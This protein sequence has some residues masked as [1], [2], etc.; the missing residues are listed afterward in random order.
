MIFWSFWSTI[1]WAQALATAALTVAI[2]LAPQAF[3]QLRYIW[4][5]WR[6]VDEPAYAAALPMLPPMFHCPCGMFLPSR[7]AAE[8]HVDAIHPGFAP[9]IRERIFRGELQP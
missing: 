4:R 7:Q 3:I 6:Q 5:A 9:E 8:L 2:A 1:D